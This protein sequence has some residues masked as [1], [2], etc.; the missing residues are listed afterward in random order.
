MQRQNWEA[1]RKIAVMGEKQLFLILYWN[2][3]HLGLKSFGNFL[4]RNSFN[5]VIIFPS[6]WLN[7]TMDD[8][9]LLNTA[10]ICRKDQRILN[11]PRSDSQLEQ[12]FWPHHCCT[13]HKHPFTFSVL[14][15]NNGLVKPSHYQSITV[16]TKNGA[17]L[18][19]T[20]FKQNMLSKKN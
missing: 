17:S 20:P 6:N 13:N 11:S 14:P 4:H 1:E 19:I 10:F 2:S 5:A 18:E 15:V 7:K 12:N 16:S 8:I 3:N 9:I